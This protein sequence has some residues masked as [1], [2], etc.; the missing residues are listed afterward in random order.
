MKIRIAAILLIACMAFLFTA[1]RSDGSGAAAD[2]SSTTE[3]ASA[4]ETTEE[5]ETTAESTST[6]D[7]ESTESSESTSGDNTSAL[8]AAESNSAVTST[9]TT[10]QAAN[11]HFP[12]N[13]ELTIAQEGVDR[14]IKALFSS[15]KLTFGSNGT[16]ELDLGSISEG[17]SGTYRINGNKLDIKSQHQ[18][19]W[20]EKNGEY[21]VTVIAAAGQLVVDFYTDY[22]AFK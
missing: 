19:T 21:K 3:G 2:I 16:Y 7:G 17:E 14:R 18:Y 5:T 1:C 8:T 9:T 6:E 20:E 12:R 15:A 22:S 4:T 10:T 11:V 13:M